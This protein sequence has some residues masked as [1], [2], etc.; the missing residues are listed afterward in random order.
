MITLADAYCRLVMVR[1]VQLAILG[2]QVKLIS[3]AARVQVAQRYEIQVDDSP[4]TGGNGHLLGFQVEPAQIVLRK[5]RLDTAFKY[6][7]R[8][9][10]FAACGVKNA[11]LFCGAGLLAEPSLRTDARC[12]ALGGQGIH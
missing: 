11:T 6:Q 2:R 1:Q 4:R 3:V 5:Q 9:A 8:C 7:P 10:V 12:F